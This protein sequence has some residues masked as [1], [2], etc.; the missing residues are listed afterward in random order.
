MADTMFGE[1]FGNMF[2]SLAPGM[3]RLTMDGRI[4]VKT[5]NAYRTYDV[6]TGRLTNCMNFVFDIGKEFFFVIPTSKVKPGDIILVN[7][8]D[9]RPSPRC[10]VTVDTN[11]ITAVNY[12]TSTQEVIIPE[13]HIFMGSTYLYGKI[14]SLLGGRMFKGKKGPN[15]I[16]RYMLMMKL[17]GGGGKNNNGYGSMDS[18]LPLL[19]WTLCSRCSSWGIRIWETYSTG[20]SMRKMMRAVSRAL[21]MTATSSDRPAH[22]QHAC[23]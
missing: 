3:C 10:V 6:K 4:A 21:A 8:A 7:D 14:V 16:F 2:G 19:L 17:F 22:A 15:Q 9:G 12:R 11:H 1:M 18:M 20:S 23:A 5:E 13:R